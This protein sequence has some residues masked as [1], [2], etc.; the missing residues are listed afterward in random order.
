MAQ[1]IAFLSYTR[2]DDAFF[3]GYIT[4]F[5]KTLEN[6]VHVVT[7]ET[8][9]Q[10]FQ[11]VEGIVI[12]E[13]WQK[14]L[15]QVIHESSFFVPMLSPLYFN[16]KACRGETTDFLEHERRL[17]RD[18]MVLPVYFMYSAN[19]EKEEKK[20]EDPLALEMARRQ[21]FDWRENADIPL[22]QPA[23]R[24]AILEL[25]SEIGARLERPGPSIDEPSATTDAEG[26]GGDGGARGARTGPESTS[27]HDERAAAL[28]DDTR[29]GVGV[30]RNVR[31]EP[32]S[33]RRIL[34]VDD[35]PGNNVW[36][37]RAL[38]SYGVEFA[39][40]RDTAQALQVIADTGPFTA[41]ISDMGRTGDRQAGLTLLKRVRDARMDTPYFI[42]TTRRAASGLW[43]VARLSKAQGITGDPDALVEMVMAAIR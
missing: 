37:R 29:L 26:Q 42:Y 39:I 28:A 27:S 22:D 14:K 20:A 9:F 23:A 8:T 31:R 18:D 16:S 5:R 7:G 24:R 17:D 10:I 36:E 12:G 3:G 43:P 19:L 30:D 33:P 35:N 4:A 15:V 13:N 34:W 21:L 1:A 38:E 41:I 32:L 40:A 25:A 2:K 11:D 6:A